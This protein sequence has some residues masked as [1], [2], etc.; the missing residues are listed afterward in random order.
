[1]DHEKPESPEPRR[2]SEAV[3]NA[4][5][6]LA[7]VGETQGRRHPDYAT[8]LNQLALLLIM[9]G[10]PGSAEPLLR[11]ALD[12]RLAALGWNHPDY[13]TN[14]SSLGGLLWA[15]GD[16]DEAEPLLRQ[17]ADIR[18]STLGR[19]HPKT[20]V[21][22]KSLEQLLK[23]KSEGIMTQAGASSSTALPLPPVPAAPMHP[24]TV[25]IPGVSPKAPAP[26][27]R[28][29]VRAGQ[30][31]IPDF[32][33]PMPPPTPTPTFAPMP[34]P[35]PPPVPV[36]SLV[37]GAGYQPP[38]AT[39]LAELG[40]GFEE[41]GRLVTSAARDATTVGALPSEE[42]MTR[43]A[44]ARHRFEALGETV[45]ASARELGLSLEQGAPASLEAIHAL[46]PAMR[47]ADERSRER[48][49]SFAQA[50]AALER[51]ERLDHPSD[52]AFAPLVS[53]RDRA[54]TLKETLAARSLEEP[55]GEVVELAEGRHPFHSLLRLV[56][57]DNSVDDTAWADL[58]EAVQSS[59]GAPLA[60]AVAR[61]RI[62]ARDN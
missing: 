35:P 49:R 39:E 22:L 44:G 41:L 47:A 32:L 21:S 38:F 2:E 10:E 4:R 27:F 14:L 54:R 53:C 29:P 62:V 51:V 19:S 40:L 46:I 52:P 59:F 57:A 56:T 25:S 11:E 43:C 48:R 1:M 37:E 61:S 42:L 9:Q 28:A 55:D 18:C 33:I 50:I 45:R 3:V 30:V 36:S 60:T 6:R 26:K 12:V 8:A 5:S 7:L 17:A 23:A 15:R 58:F 13:A 34:P 16:L 31:E 20:V 24:Q